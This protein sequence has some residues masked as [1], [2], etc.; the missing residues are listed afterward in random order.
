MKIRYSLILAFIII[1]VVPG[2]AQLIDQP[3]ATVDLVRMEPITAKQLD[4]KLESVRTLSMQAGLSP[5]VIDRKQVLESMIA[6][7]LLRQG[8]ERKKINVSAEEVNNVVTTLK[9]NA[10][11]QVGRELTQIEFRSLVTQQTGMTWDQY[12][13]QLRSELIKQQYVAVEKRS[14]LDAVKNPTDREIEKRYFENANKF[15][16]PEYVRFSQVYISTVNLAASEKSRARENAEKIFSRYRNGEMS[17]SELVEQ[18][19]EDA[20]SK[21]KQGDAGYVGRDNQQ[22]AQLFGESFFDTLFDAEVGAVEGVYESRVGFH[23]IKITEHEYPKILKLEDPVSPTNSMTVREYIRAGILQERQQ[24]ALQR[25]LEELIG[26]L[27]KEAEIR[28]FD[29]SLQ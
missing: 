23:I 21:Y 25:A 29:E 19:S 27:K 1:V 20:S 3:V 6:E 4:N 9:R 22:V 18:Y 28:L 24:E 5:G 17:F 8:A 7:I 2:F 16:N 15:T 11:A 26:E 13:A 12:T 14:V 10:E